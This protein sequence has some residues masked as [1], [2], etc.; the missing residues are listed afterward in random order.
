MKGVLPVSTSL[1]GLNFT[2]LEGKY[3]FGSPS[4]T[5]EE[6]EEGWLEAASSV[7]SRKSVVKFVVLHGARCKLT[8]SCRTDSILGGCKGDAPVVTY[9]K[10]ATATTK[11]KQH[12]PQHR[13]TKT[14]SRH[15]G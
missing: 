3:R 11:A 8:A 13:H 7:K 14:Y 5:L 4:E 12:N 10:A 1:K 2:I 9:A 15:N 6:R